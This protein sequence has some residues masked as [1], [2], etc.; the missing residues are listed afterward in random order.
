M[1]QQ[2][3]VTGA[4]TIGVG[5]L[6]GGI[7]NA[8]AIWMLFHPYEP[9]GIGPFRL[10]GA[11]PKNKDRLAK[12]IAKTVAERLLTREDLAARLS[13]PAVR[14]AFRGALDRLL[15]N[16]LERERGPLREQLSPDLVRAVED[17]VSAL[18]PRL[19]GHV[20]AYT[21]SPEFESLATRWLVRLR[22]DLDGRPIGATLTEERRAALRRAVDGWVGQLADGDE[23]ESVLRRFVN[24]QLDRMAREERPL[25]DLLP[26]GLTGTLEH[27]ITDY[28][29]VALERLGAL[30]A[31]PEAR[32][33]IEDALRDA[34]DYSVRELLIHERLLAKLMVTDR[35]I[36]RLVDGFEREGFD[37]FADA[38][39]DP[40]MKAH[41]TRAVNEAIV[42]F[43]RQPLGER[44]RRLGP[45]RREALARTLGDWLLRVARDPSTRAVIAR[46]VDRALEAAEQRT[47]GEVVGMLPA[48]QVSALV[49][50]ALAAP[51]S[52]AR[53]TR[54]V[55]QIARR[56]LD[57]PVGRPAAWL[58]V[59]ASATLRDAVA[60]AAWQAVQQQVPRVVE[61]LQ[62]QEMVEQRVRGF[63]TARM[64]EIVRTVTQ[65]ELDLIVYLGYWLGGLVG[66]IAF[67]INTALR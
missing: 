64:E 61:Q 24:E 53:V 65:R 36:E 66:L 52:Q 26:L 62:V 41:V 50:E 57:R 17:G 35:T 51:R 5:A 12:S 11:I 25:L 37:R 23:L 16:L 14:D 20:A 30:L 56:I 22:A 19:A 54:A 38:V 4:V 49:G 18:A 67:L 58:G 46:T 47:W 8:V 13:A 28:L 1:D 55:R 3:L 43:L 6:A 42:R 63:S 10:Q 48:K 44:L 32:R 39:T 59:D 31:D 2:T 27:A 45:E 40:A 9:T 33:V 15:D 29:P 34:F 60:D 7:T 21:T